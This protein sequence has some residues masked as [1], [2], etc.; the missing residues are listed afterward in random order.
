M[1]LF[2]IIHKAPYV[3]V[4]SH[5]KNTK[6]LLDKMPKSNMAAHKQMDDVTVVDTFVLLFI[7]YCD[8]IVFINQVFTTYIMR[9]D[10]YEG[11]ELRGCNS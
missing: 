4:S 11:E 5:Y 8:K 2:T 3:L 9:M 1:V 7:T 10:G 6:M